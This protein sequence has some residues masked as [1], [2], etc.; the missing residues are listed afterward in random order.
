MFGAHV[1][2]AVHQCVDGG[3]VVYGHR[4]L[5]VGRRLY[6]LCEGLSIRI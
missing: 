1:A 3:I 5:T 4:A 2:V 6:A